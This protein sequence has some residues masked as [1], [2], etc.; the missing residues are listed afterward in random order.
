MQGIQLPRVGPPAPPPI[1]VASPLNDVQ[2]VALV[3]AIAVYP[4]DQNSEATAAEKVEYALDLV[5]EAIA[6][7]ETLPARVRAKQ[8]ARV[9]C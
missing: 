1:M 7:T 3:A 2:L 4:P 9:D 5:A 6:Q 8:A